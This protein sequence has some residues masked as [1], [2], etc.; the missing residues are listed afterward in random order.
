MSESKQQ[1][2]HVLEQEF[3][4]YER[5]SL[6]LKVTSAIASFFLAQQASLMSVAGL[7]VFIWVLDAIWKTFQQR[8][9]HYLERLEAQKVTPC[10][11]HLDWQKNRPGT[12]GLVL[13]YA[14]TGLRP[15]VMLP[16]LLLLVLIGATSIQL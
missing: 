16:H 2:W 4:D 11:L 15:T 13:E 5:C 3:H 1:H 8:T 9:G 12:L 10:T 14:K 6:A 7:I